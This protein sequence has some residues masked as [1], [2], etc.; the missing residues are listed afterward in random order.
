[1]RFSISVACSALVF[2]VGF[3]TVVSSAETPP[4]NTIVLTVQEAIRSALERNLDLAND[5][6]RLVEADQTISYAKSQ[7]FPTVSITGTVQQQKAAITGVGSAPFGGDP[8]NS[9]NAQI[10]L[11]QPLYAGNLISSGMAAARQQKE[12]REK[13]LEVARRDLTVE[14]MELFYTILTTRETV[15]Y[16]KQVK[17]VDEQS[18]ATS[19][20]YYRVGR[21]QLIDVL[22]AKTQLSLVLPQIETVE[23]QMKV[24]ASQLVTLLHETQANTVD[25]VGTVP[26]VAP[27]KIRALLTKRLRLAEILRGELQIAQFQ[28]QAEVALS[29]NFPLL[30]FQA[31]WGRQAYT[32]SDMLNNYANT[33]SFGLSLT[34][35]V[36]SGLSS[37]YQRGVLS[38]Q[39]SQ[40]EFGQMKLL[41]QLSFN[42]VQSER[43]LD[44]S[45]TVLKG[46]K[47]AADYARASLTEAQR[48]FRLQTINYL[49]LLQSEQTFL[50]AQLSYTQAR[51]SYVDSVAKYFAAT[52]IPI[53]LLVEMLGKS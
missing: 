41:D 50:S 29:S 16:L 9:Y 48:D 36:F 26:Y 12:V 19:E 30:S 46:S 37:V 35:P 31:A 32:A 21:A 14:V 40:L 25:L 7:I 34:I 28:S 2:S 38:S 3:G 42:Q 23:N 15:E 17:A 6:E 43:N 39:K 18:L 1:M 13:D 51:Y 20:R 53:E 11:N 8:Y 45:E 49:Q 24:A 33:W 27:E 5:R 44:T 47:Q 52:G 22:Q 10:K 4:Q